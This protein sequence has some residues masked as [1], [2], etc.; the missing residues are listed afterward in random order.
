[1]SK[2]LEHLKRVELHYLG[3]LSA[4]NRY[5]TDFPNK[6][7]FRQLSKREKKQYRLW[8]KK[9]FW[10]QH[11]AVQE[12]RAG[13]PFDKAFIW[14]VRT[15]SFIR[16]L[17]R[18][19]SPLIKVAKPEL[20]AALKSLYPERPI[21]PPM[22]PAA[23]PELIVCRFPRNG[24][25]D[26]VMSLDKSLLY[27]AETYLRDKPRPRRHDPNGPPPP[28]L[29]VGYDFEFQ[30]AKDRLSRLS[31]KEK[32]LYLRQAKRNLP[33]RKREGCLLTLMLERLRQLDEEC[34]GE[35]PVPP[36]KLLLLLSSIES[37]RRSLK[38][39][40]RFLKR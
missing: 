4:G 28:D 27:H 21:P 36:G 18:W 19:P 10:M 14:I 22:K 31:W 11:V 1:M 15:D 9:A 40:P 2:I 6:K 8:E 16:A 29:P 17:R 30:E 33:K 7:L 5:S 25:E 3:N 34:G 38:T 37:I 35:S 39:L 26:M 20:T 23:P 24:R 32:R 13:L 12:C